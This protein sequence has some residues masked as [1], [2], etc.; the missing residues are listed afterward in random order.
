MLASIHYSYSIRCS[1]VQILLFSIQYL[2]HYSNTMMSLTLLTVFPL[3]VPAGT[4]LFFKFS[5]K[6]Y[7]AKQC[8]KVRV[9]FKGVYNSRACTVR[10][11]TVIYT[12]KSQNFLNFKIHC[13]SNGQNGRVFAASKWPKLILRKIWAAEKFLKFYTKQ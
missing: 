10:G 2:S 13:C 7:Q 9:Q 4:I 6:K 11:N 8:Q 12:W 3:F 1:F 5:R